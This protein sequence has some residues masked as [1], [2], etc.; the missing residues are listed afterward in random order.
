MSNSPR[1]EVILWVRENMWWMKGA[2]AVVATCGSAWVAL[3]MAQQAQAVA[4]AQ[5]QKEL[6]E[7]KQQIA[8]QRT[9]LTAN[10]ASLAKDL[11]IWREET[12]RR[13]RSALQQLNTI[14]RDMGLLMGRTERTGGYIPTPSRMP[15]HDDRSVGS[16]G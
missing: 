1:F 14:A 15:V 4:I 6:P 9:D 5:V 2:G 7:I 3:F 16:G 10:Q 11:S 8:E 13:D 12:A